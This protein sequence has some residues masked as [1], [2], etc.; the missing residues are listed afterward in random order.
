VIRLPRL[1]TPLILV[2]FKAYI[3]SV[4]GK[5]LE[6]AKKAEKISNQTGVC[7]GLAPQYTDINQIAEAVSLP[8]FSQHLDP[9]MPG[10]HTGQVLAEA[11]ETAGAI[12]TLINHSE[13]RMRLARID[14]AI[15]RARE[16]NLVTVVCTNNENVSA[17]AAYLKPTYIA[18]EPPELI[19]TGIPVS[20]AK[21]DIVTET[22]KLVKKIN[23]EVI[24]LCGAGITKGDDVVSALKLG[25][26]GI[27]V[28][29]GVV[30][31]KEPSKIL[32]EFA[33]ATLS[34]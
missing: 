26:Q 33:E 6:L 4:G 11:L 14:A 5:A 15:Q 7:I 19:G 8:V 28:A 9:I 17:S 2:N 25:T 12:G 16:V 29:S 23:T 30:K 10:S 18:I 34:V 20:Q 31:A 3:E 32:L 27:L 1:W 24:V 22:V 21:P 13:K